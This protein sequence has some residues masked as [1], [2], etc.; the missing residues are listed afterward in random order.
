[1]PEANVI[2]DRRLIIPSYDSP[3]DYVDGKRAWLAHIEK[4]PKNLTLLENA[5]SFLSLGDR[6]TALDLLRR[7]QSLDL[8][9]PKWA[10]K[11]GG[12]LLRKARGYRG[13]TDPLVA[14]LALVQLERANDRPGRDGW[15]GYLLESLAKAALA[16]EDHDK[17]RKYA[18]LML[19]GNSPREVTGDHIHHGHLTLGRVALAE[20]D[21]AQAK[22]RLLMAGKSPGSRKLGFAGPNMALA[23]E[24]LE[25]GHRKIVLKYFKSCAKLWTADRGKAKLDE[26]SALVAAGRIPDFGANLAY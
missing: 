14:R 19:N 2:H 8:S 23:K 9:N 24:L 16:A 1:M 22:N 3:E 18:G 21:V 5:A 7:A 26:W 15:N 12:M 17:A 11:L 13:E 4:E 6:E 25:R 10:M 20:G